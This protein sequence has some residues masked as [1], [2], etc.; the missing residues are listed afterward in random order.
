MIPHLREQRGGRIIQLSSMGGQ[1]SFPGLSLYHATKWGI[2]GFL[3]SVILEVAPFGIEITIVE[4]GMA[5]TDFSGRSMD[6]APKLEIYD[7]QLKAILPRKTSS[8][9]S[10]LAV[11][12]PAKIAKAII[13][14]AEQS[15]APKRL[16]L[17][18]DAYQLVTAALRERLSSLEGARELAYSTDADDIVH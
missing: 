8:H 4:P 2:E 15:P 9:S 3:E 7:E 17:G 18:S 10:S 6:I 5:R 12:D 13:N 14:S 1:I 16:T 11:G